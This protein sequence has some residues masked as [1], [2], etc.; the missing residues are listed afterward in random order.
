ML[1]KYL[2]V[3]VGVVCITSL[4]WRGSLRDSTNNGFQATP[5][6]RELDESK[7]QFREIAKEAGIEFHNQ[8]WFPNKKISASTLALLAI[9]PS[10]SIYDVDS[11]GRPD[12]LLTDAHPAG[13][14]KLYLNRSQ[15]GR[16]AFEE[17]SRQYGLGP[18]SLKPGISRAIFGD[19]NHDGKIDLV[20]ARFGCHEVLLGQGPNRPFQ[21][22]DNALQGY[23]SNV[24]GLNLADFDRDG[25]LDIFFSAYWK[26]ED[27]SRTLP[28]APRLRSSRSEQ[29]G[30]KRVV[31][32]GLGDG[33]FEMTDWL[34]FLPRSYSNNGGIADI[35]GDG[36]LDLYIANDYQYDF[37]VFNQGAGKGFRE[38]TDQWAPQEYHGLNGM[39][40]DFGDFNRDGRLDL[41]VSNISAPPFVAYNNIL[42]THMGDRYEDRSRE[43]GA[44]HCGWSWSGK[45]A[46]FDNDGQL[47][48][49]VA[50][51]RARGPGSTADEA[52]SLWHARAIAL[53]VPF[54]L[55]KFD[56]LLDYPST[57]GRHLSGFA[58]SCV[59]R[60]NSGKFWDVAPFSGVTDLEEGY[61]LAL[62]DLDSDGRMDFVVSNL[63]G[64]AV[65]YHNQT[66]RENQRW[67][68]FDL[69][70][71]AGAHNYGA[72]FELELSTGNK[73]I[74]LHFPSNGFNS[75]SDHRVHFG[76]SPSD[77]EPVAL[78]VK[79]PTTA[80]A[81]TA[82]PGATTITTPWQKTKYTELKSLSYNQIRRNA[83]EKLP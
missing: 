51:G 72:E 25:H 12:L 30:G 60:Q 69:G 36:W 8:L 57:K 24:V 18:D 79:W 83:G 34:D 67:I 15:P 1:R 56:P 49:A 22:L 55:R 33:R 65:L 73:L 74:A 63:G 29:P 5:P 20:V 50:N 37:L 64:P 3:L 28:K 77:G 40:A 7:I 35:N 31:M 42:W 17:A 76:L 39:N 59:F 47:D 43:L 19:V 13:G 54:F 82:V 11:D 6:K 32:R 66:E 80:T 78:I 81:P 14:M 68:G 71:D 23:C 62:I 21:S 4:V 10:T 53:D 16:P 38:V 61:G 46:D 27:L 48:L 52:R 9:F 58:R 75:Q 41:Y 26:E 2:S 70:P 44:A 45:W